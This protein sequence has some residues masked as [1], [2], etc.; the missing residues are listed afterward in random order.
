MDDDLKPVKND[1]MGNAEEGVLSALLKDVMRLATYAVEVGR[2]PEQ[3]KLSEIYRLW[4][5]KIDQAQ[6]LNEND[7]NLLESYYRKLEDELSP[8]TAVS[9][10]ATDAKKDSRKMND[11]MDSEAGKY[12]RRMWIMSFSILGLI[13]AIN[14]FQYVFH[15]FS[16]DWAIAMEADFAYVTIVY[17]LAGGITPFAYGAFGACIRLLRVTEQRLRDRTFDP[18]RIPEHR[19]RMVLGTLS[20]GVIV[21]LYSTGGISETDVKLTEAGLGFLAGYSIDLLFSI[22]DRLVKA[23][24]PE[25]PQSTEGKKKMERKK[26]V[27]RS[28]SVVPQHESKKIINAVSSVGEEKTPTTKVS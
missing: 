25:S 8:V 18:R 17:W 1:S 27:I 21:L 15:M 11:Y 23:L 13:M 7:I 26:D 6:C 20:G 14:L 16:A 4:D 24:S 3:V 5:I 28:N 19:N 22:L 10:F 9:L 2:L 12:A